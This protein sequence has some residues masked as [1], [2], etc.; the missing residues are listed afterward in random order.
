VAAVAAR[1][2]SMER[3]LFLREL[4]ELSQFSVA[5][6]SGVPRARISLSESGQL[7]LT[8]EEMTRIRSVLLKTIEARANQLL[9]VLADARSEKDQ[10]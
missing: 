5:R 1:G 9:S 8:R 3:L 4:S 7:E 2:R 6:R 10:G